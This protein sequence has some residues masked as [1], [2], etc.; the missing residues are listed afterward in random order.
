MN[1]KAISTAV[2]RLKFRAAVGVGALPLKS[3]V[4]VDFIFEVCG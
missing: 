3:P 2:F 4:E 1:V